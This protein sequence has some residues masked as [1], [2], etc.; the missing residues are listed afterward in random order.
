MVKTTDFRRC[1]ILVLFC[2]LIYNTNAQLK[3]VIEDFEGIDYGPSDLK[4][5]GIFVYGNIKANIDGTLSVQQPYSGERSLKVNKEGALNYGGW[6]KGISLNVEL[7]VRKDYF[8]FYV[9]SAVSNGTSPLKIELQEDDNGDG[10]YDKQQDDSWI[11]VQKIEGKNSWQ[12]I[13]I[14]LANFKDNNEGGDD[15]FNVSYKNGKLLC[16]IF[17]F[18]DASKATGRPVWSFDF[19]SLS[20]GTL[21]T[22]PVVFSAPAASSGDFCT[23]GLWSKEGNS[24]NYSDIAIN[25]ENSFKYGS[26]KKLGVIHFFQPFSFD[27]GNTQNNYPTVEH[28]N[29]V[30]KE[31]Y[32]PLVT[33]E[34]HFVNLKPGTRQP[35]LYSI[36]EG[37][38]DSFFTDW[39]KQIKQVK[40]T[41]LLR[42]LHE[43]NGDWYPWCTVNNDKNPDLVIKA[44][45]HIHDLF[46][47]QQ[48]S[49]VKFI[50]CPNSMSLPQEKWN[51]IMDAYPGDEYVDFVALDIYNGAGKGIPVWRSFRK[52]GIENYFVLNQ[53]LAHKTLFVCEVASREREPFESKTSQ[54]KAEW[55]R[56]M[57]EAL[58]TDMSKIRLLVWFNEKGTFKITSSKESQYAY[59]NNILNNNYFKS[60]NGT[61]K[62]VTIK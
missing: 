29:K 38:F 14:P 6:G 52:E 5:N 51:F 22:G 32:T 21:P 42:I 48:V 35:N 53:R 17:S 62:E 57:S 4:P 26:D 7:D 28:I 13:S 9:Y 30:I 44:Y 15:G 8:N 18:D 55:I 50:W 40:G 27:G 33:F 59:L 11:C 2:F 36:I 47:K 45:R 20:E 54:N 49:N 16:L 19:I 37:H 41:V 43:F 60:G 39:A 12:L 25:F 1:G 3:F 10:A 46:A 61:L 23:L 31:G 24:A 34:D 56:Q 58:S